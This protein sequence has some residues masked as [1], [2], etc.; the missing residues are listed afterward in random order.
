MVPYFSDGNTSHSGTIRIMCIFSAARRNPKVAVG[1]YPFIAM[2]SRSDVRRAA[3][4]TLFLKNIRIYVYINNFTL[5]AAKHVFAFILCI[6]YINFQEYR[7]RRPRDVFTPQKKS[8]F[9]PSSKHIIICD[10]HHFP[11]PRRRR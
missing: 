11:Y 8:N 5:C 4:N 10:R 3:S 7:Y 2:C 9:S 1:S 6:V